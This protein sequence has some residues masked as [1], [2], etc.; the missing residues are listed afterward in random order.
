[1]LYRRA[2]SQ[3]DKVVLLSGGGSGHEPAHAGYLGEGMLDVVVAGE[4]FA[5]PSS[6]QILAGIQAAPSKNG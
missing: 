6:S 1:M 5:S 4:I 2:A 3:N